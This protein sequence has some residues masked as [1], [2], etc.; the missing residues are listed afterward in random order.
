MIDFWRNIHIP[1]NQPAGPKSEGNVGRLTKSTRRISG[2]TQ[3]VPPALQR[4]AIA[5]LG[6]SVLTWFTTL[7]IR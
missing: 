6:S 7:K 4:K 5:K 3:T 2:L 1:D